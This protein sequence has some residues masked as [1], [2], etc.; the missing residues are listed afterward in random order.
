MP[1]VYKK[2]WKKIMLG[3]SDAWSLSRP[4]EPAYYIEDCWIFGLLKQPIIQFKQVQQSM[5][6]MLGANCPDMHCVCNRS[7]MCICKPSFCCQI[8][9]YWG[10][11]QIVSSSFI[12]KS[13]Q[14]SAQFSTLNLKIKVLF[15]DHYTW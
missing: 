14:L 6:Q 11:V 1:Y 5:Q 15:T 7:V 10:S 12:L 3:T 2:L 4:S 9:C 8:A 13:V